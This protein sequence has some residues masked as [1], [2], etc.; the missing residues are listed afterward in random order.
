MSFKC[1]LQVADKT[2]EVLECNVWLNQKFDKNGR[3]ASG[4]QGGNIILLLEGSDDD[5][6]GT[7]MADPT[8]KQD[9]VITFFRIDQDSK[10]KELEFKG[11]YAITLIE[12][13]IADD[14]V[15]M[16]P[17]LEIATD[18]E[19]GRAKYSRILNF[20]RRTNNSY[21]IY[22]QISAQKIKVDGVEHDNRW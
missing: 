13:F 22:F 10:S 4:V 6:L 20:H 9:G 7:W 2:F 19:Q 15:S 18:D 1:T 11:G 14:D 5:T 21:V 12:S 3:P 17:E 16:I 8:K